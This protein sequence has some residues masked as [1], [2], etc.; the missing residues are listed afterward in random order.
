ME[1]PCRHRLESRVPETRWPVCSTSSHLQQL[2]RDDP[3]GLWLPV[4]TP[5]EGQASCSVCPV[6]ALALSGCPGPRAAALRSE[7]PR[8][9]QHRP[10]PRLLHHTT[11]T[12]GCQI[13]RVGHHSL[14]GHSAGGLGVPE[15]HTTPTRGALARSYSD[16]CFLACHSRGTSPSPTST[17]FMWP[18]PQDMAWPLHRAERMWPKAHPDT[19][20]LGSKPAPTAPRSHQQ[21]RV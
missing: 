18:F 2:C 19:L 5:G 9:G 4:T 11:G 20:G 1:A 13:Q 17:L 12:H 21:Q 14:P 6:T 16:P 10:F 8:L 3:V 7:R 15:P